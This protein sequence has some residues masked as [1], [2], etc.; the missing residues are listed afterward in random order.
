MLKQTEKTSFFRLLGLLVV[1][2]AIATTQIAC[3][4]ATSKPT[5]NAPGEPKNVQTQS[6]LPAEV[7][8]PTSANV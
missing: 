6:Q 4:E 1:M 7:E 2:L 3:K 8:N 5:P